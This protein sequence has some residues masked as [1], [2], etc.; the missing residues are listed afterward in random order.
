MQIELKHIP[1]REALHFLGWRGAPVEETLMERIAALSDE[2]IRSVQPRVMM[3]RFRIEEGG[4]LEGTAF[5]PAGESIRRMLAPCHEAV[6]LAATL[7]AQS[8]RMLLRMQAKDAAQALLLDAVLSA[9][10]EEV[11][12][13]AEDMLRAQMTGE[14]LYL[15]DRFSPGYGDMP[16]AQSK[17][18]CE[19][20][21]SGKTI[22]LTVSGSGVM[23]PRK[24]V[25]AVMG[26]SRRAVVKRMRGCES[27]A[28]RESCAL[29]EMKK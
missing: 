28:M 2:V 18:I 21:Q 20:L 5:S 24:S 4:R 16:L 14:G 10:I 3:R 9:A 26:V 22:G 6:L 7:D 25:T 13:L 8:E 17:E 1:V 19:V 23:I 27:C 11:C 15:T 12:E 29:S